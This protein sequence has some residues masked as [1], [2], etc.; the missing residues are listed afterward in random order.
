MMD[1]ED[2]SS[3]EVA[4]SLPPDDPIRQKWESEAT[5]QGSN[6]ADKWLAELQLTDRM[7]LDMRDVMPP[8]GLDE[9]LL[10][11]PGSAL[12]SVRF[13]RRWGT[14]LAT[15]AA[16]L[17]IIGFVMLHLRRIHRPVSFRASTAVVAFDVREPVQTLTA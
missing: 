17:L 5:A 6:M 7:R 3:L 14:V 4:A 11:I 16:F 10:R 15:V 9:R 8:A 13:W 2:C 12:E 1:N